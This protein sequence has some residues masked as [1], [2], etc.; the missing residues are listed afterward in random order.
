MNHGGSI[1][2]IYAY[3]SREDQIIN[4]AQSENGGSEFFK[5]ISGLPANRMILEHVNL[6]S[7][8]LIHEGVSN[9][10][11][12]RIG[13]GDTLFLSGLRSLGDSI[14]DIEKAFIFFAQRNVIVRFFEEARGINDK[15]R[16]FISYSIAPK[17]FKYR[18]EMNY[19]VNKSD[20]RVGRPFG[21]KHINDIQSYKYAGYTQTFTAMIL[22]VS[23]ST[24]KRY[25]R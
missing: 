1:L 8:S 25:W 19:L 15:N 6:V 24:V 4:D 5:I 9:L 14:D 22:K 7:A 17:S 3:A 10:I 21:S 12:A 2:A 16:Y 20:N 23:L 13:C 11:S 18:G